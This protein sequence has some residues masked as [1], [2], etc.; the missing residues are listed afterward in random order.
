MDLS[1]ALTLTRVTL[2]AI[3]QELARDPH[4]KSPHT[5]RGYLND[6]ARFEAWRGGRLLTKLL[7]EEYAAHLQAQGRA[8][9]GINRALAAIR[10]WARRLGDLAY[11]DTT[12]ERALRDEIAS[13]AARVAGIGDV[14]GQRQEKGRHITAGELAALL[15]TCANNQTPAGA[16][17]AALI[18]LVWVTGMRR[19][20]LAGL[21]LEDYEAKG[22]APGEA[23]ALADWLELRGRAPGPLFYVIRKGGHIQYGAGISDEALAQMLAKRA[24][25]AG[26]KHLTWHDFRRSFA[27]NLLDAGHDLATPYG[28][29]LAD[30]N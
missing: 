26:M 4:L 6:L 15:D 28:P 21:R 24:R 8:P 7:V 17:D 25:E 11:E 29:R 2:S 16:R 30:D 20:E 23:E 14:R 13:Q 3:A 19:S 22:D 27:G 18:A 9:R 5:R 1:L 10:W 12:V